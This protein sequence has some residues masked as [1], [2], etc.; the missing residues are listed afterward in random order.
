MIILKLIGHEYFNEV[1]DIIKLFFGK[2]EVKLY[3]NSK[4]YLDQKGVLITSQIIKAD[5]LTSFTSSYQK[6]GNKNEN[7]NCYTYTRNGQVK[8]IKTIKKSLK[9]SMYN[10]LSGITD[11]DLPWGILTGIRPV[12]IV[13]QLYEDGMNDEEIVQHLNDEY[14]VN[15]DRALLS[16]NIAQV[17][18]KYIEKNN[19]HQVS[20][21]I[22]IPFCPS[23]CGYCSFTSND[24]GKNRDVV[25]PY[26]EALVLEI[27]EVSAYLKSKGITAQT[28]YIG[29]GTPTSINAEELNMLIQC[30]NEYWSGSKEFTCEAGRPDTITL[31]KLKVIKE[32]GVTRLSIN[33]QTMDDDTLVRIGRKHTHAQ[34]IESFQLARSLGFD[35]INMDMIIGLPGE[36]M[37]QAENTLNWMNR[38]NPENVTVHTL[39]LKRASIYNEMNLDIRRNNNDTASMME[40]ARKKLGSNGYYP[41]YLYRQKYMAENLENIGFCKK[42]K[43]CIYNIQIMEEKQSIIAF[44]ADAVTKAYFPEEDRLERQHN[45]KDLKLYIDNIHNQINK[46]LEL[47]S[48]LNL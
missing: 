29:G 39:A 26:L 23:R 10:L 24:V 14:L 48:L 45:I 34:V 35:N 47:L 11:K 18:K 28:I 17:E 7:S 8:D 20:I 3:D 37:E 21:Y 44:G 33:P 13:H 46:K 32:G 22:G 36:G 12:K 15:E 38:L 40:L 25:L 9:L 6:L 41:Y 42:D 4:N 19:K 1:T 30:I 16:I 31:D 5:D 43:E 2:E 27:R